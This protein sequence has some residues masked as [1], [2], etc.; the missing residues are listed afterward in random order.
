MNNYIKKEYFF[1]SEIDGA[2]LLCK[3]YKLERISAKAMKLTIRN[4]KDHIEY[5]AIQYVDTIV[6]KVDKNGIALDTG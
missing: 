6:I 1:E 2:I 5:M 3:E 4:K